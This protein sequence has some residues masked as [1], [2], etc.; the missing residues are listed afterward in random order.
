M[1]DSFC[2]MVTAALSAVVTSSKHIGEQRN[3]HGGTS[4]EEKTSLFPLLFGRYAKRNGTFGSSCWLD[5]AA[6]SA[7][8]TSTKLIGERSTRMGAQ[9]GRKRQAYSQLLFGREREG[10]ASLREAASLA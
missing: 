10:G 3:S 1:L 6:L 4:W 8:V 2:W 5:A 7:A 9:A